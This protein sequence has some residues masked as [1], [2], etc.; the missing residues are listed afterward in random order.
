M[1]SPKHADLQHGQGYPTCRWTETNT[2][3]SLLKGVQGWLWSNTFETQCIAEKLPRE[4]GVV[5]EVF[6]VIGEI[7]TSG[8]GEDQKPW[9]KPGDSGDAGP[10]RR[11]HPGSTNAGGDGDWT[12]SGLLLSNDRCLFAPMPCQYSTTTSLVYLKWSDF[13]EPGLPNDK[14]FRSLARRSSCSRKRLSIRC[15]RSWSS[16]QSGCSLK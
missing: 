15:R 1:F 10:G 2:W 11:P 12:M 14:L 7:G 16:S 13:V 6:V 5:E 9:P 4:D 8:A 3:P